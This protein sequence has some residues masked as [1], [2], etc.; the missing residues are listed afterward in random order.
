[1]SS[2]RV[3]NLLYHDRAGLDS[4]VQTSSSNSPIAKRALTIHGRPPKSLS[5][6]PHTP[7]DV[8]L[9]SLIRLPA[10]QRLNGVDRLGDVTELVGRLTIL[11]WRV[12][13]EITDQVAA[14]ITIQ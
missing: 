2:S 6:T 8:A 9:A 3:D 12:N 5:T 14:A 1:M 10:R 4:G 7:V 11:R 13:P